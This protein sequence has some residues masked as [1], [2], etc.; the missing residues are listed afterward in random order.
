MNRCSWADPMDPLYLAYHD[1][2]WGI[3]CRDDR[4]L[5]EMLVLESFQA[6]LSWACILHKRE[7]FRQAFDG[8]DPD[9]VSRYTED[10]V[11]I[12]MQN[13]GIVRNRRKIL[14]AIRN[15]AV[16]LSIQAEYGSFSDY[17]WG[18]TEGKVV[19][20]GDAV[21]RATSPLSDR[22]SADLKKRGMTFV[23]STIVYAYLQA[24]GVI[25]D[26]EPSCDRAHNRRSRL[27][28]SD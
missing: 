25:D 4:R 10:R 26:H 19:R 27:D 12:L 17:L 21:I 16:Y 20:Y 5:F 3:P 24:V 14:A 23:G 2:E 9:I 6:G 7:A 8:F 22:V 18:F 13:K 11:A 1:D 28:D 15:A